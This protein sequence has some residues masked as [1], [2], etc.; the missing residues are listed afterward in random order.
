MR[1]IIALIA[2]GTVS[3]LLWAS[4]VETKARPGAPLP[5]GRGAAAVPSAQSPARAPHPDAQR[6][7]VLNARLLTMLESGK[8]ARLDRPV[9]K[10]ARPRRALER[11]ASGA[12]VA[13]ARTPSLALPEPVRLE[14]RPSTLPMPTQIRPARASGRRYAAPRLDLTTPPRI[15]GSDLECLAQAIYYE[16]RNESEDGQAAVA[17]VV[18]NRARSGAYPR[19]ICEVVYQRNSRTCQFT[20]TCDGSIGRGA[21]NENAWRRSERIAREVLGGASSKRLPGN[22]LNYHANYVSPSWGRRLQRVRQIGAHIFYGTATR[23]V[24]PGA[25]SAPPKTSGLQ[26]V[27][28]A[29]LDRYNAS[30]VEASAA[31]PSAAQSN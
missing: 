3:G 22:S 5:D 29:A 21:I 9:A 8:R 25:E 27:S 18:V 20:F 4:D 15:P 7:D 13:P 11:P 12:T 10:I 19:Q 23:G 26:F 30:A 17:E 6:R 16:A 1:K 14:T 28:I 2:V 24:T 31:S